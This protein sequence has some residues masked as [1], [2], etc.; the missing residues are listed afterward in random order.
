MMKL[1]KC[2]SACLVTCQ[3]WA[4]NYQEHKAIGNAAL[5]AA[6]KRAVTSGLF[7]DSASAV[8][9]LKTQLLL[10]YDE[11]R[12]EWQ[13]AELS[14]EPNAISYGDLNGLSGDH[15]SDP[16]E[17][18]DQLSYR[19]SVLNRIVMLQNQYGEQFY[20]NAPD[21]VLFNTDFQYGML[22]LTNFSHFYAYGKSLTWHLQTVDK[23]DITDLL[24]PANTRRVFSRLQRQN[25][26]RMYVTLHAV[27]VQLA[28]MAGQYAHQNDTSNARKLLFYAILYN[29]FADHFIQDMCAAGHMVV[30]RTL[31]GGVTNNRA[32]HDFYNNVGLNVLNLKGEVWKT[33][34]DGTLNSPN[35]E[36]RD[37]Q[38]FVRLESTPVTV[39]FKRA[40]DAAG[41]SVYEIIEAYLQSQKSGWADFVESIPDSQGRDQTDEREAFYLTHFGSLSLVPLPFES[42]VKRYFKENPQAK[43]FTN[44]NRIPFY[45]NYVRSRVA[46][47]L[48]IG[49]GRT[50]DLTNTDNFRPYLTF[51]ARLNLSSNKYNYHD[52]ANK[53]GTFDTWRGWTASYVGGTQLVVEGNRVQD[54]IRFHQI[55]GGLNYIGDLWITNNTY[56]GF[57]TYLET[58]VDL[59]NGKPAWLISPSVG[60]QF[61]PFV[62]AQTRGFSKLAIRILQLIVSQKWVASYQLI[63]GRPAQLFIQSE[64]D[65]SL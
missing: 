4:Y 33:N 17:M 11:K 1:L 65:I 64:F 27:A 60:L 53:R 31:T 46:N 50:R 44:I 36:W 30:K 3:A 6:V 61:L 54:R 62:G 24:V 43:E 28:Q 35:G 15:E 2:I 21:K 38:S 52:R 7:A 49:L 34:G 56:F 58:G 45:R 29:A 19:Y 57:H 23:Q 63:A 10:R 42:D 25:V 22:A 47:S 37:A 14:Q 40:I 39:K 8:A 51:E 13:F 55:K 18:K 32:I 26:V 16:L 12:R 9:F 5:S 20:T 48:I 41:Q 59:R